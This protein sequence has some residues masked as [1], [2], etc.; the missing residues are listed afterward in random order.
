MTEDHKVI[1]YSERLR[2]EGMG[3][4]LKDGETRL[5]GTCKFLH[6]TITVRSQDSAALRYILSN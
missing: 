6:L 4:P 1:S 2:M 5:C 3:E